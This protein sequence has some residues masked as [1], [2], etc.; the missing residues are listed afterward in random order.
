MEIWKHFENRPE[1]FGELRLAIQLKSAE[2]DILGVSQNYQNIQF[3]EL[4]FLSHSFLM[5]SF[6]TPWKHQKTFGFLCLQGVEKGCIGNEWV[7]TC[8]SLRNNLQWVSE[9]LE[10]FENCHFISVL[11]DLVNLLVWNLN[12]VYQKQTSQLKS[13][14]L[15]ILNKISTSAECSPPGKHLQQNS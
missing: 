6:S 5:H 12:Q 7:N 14:L 13:D 8:K 10:R 2:N 9:N 4:L 3:L 11:L 1:V 15:Y